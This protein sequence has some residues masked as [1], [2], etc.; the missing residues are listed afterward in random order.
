MLLEGNVCD[1][2]EWAAVFGIKPLGFAEG[3]RGYLKA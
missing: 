2:T 1:P 3:I